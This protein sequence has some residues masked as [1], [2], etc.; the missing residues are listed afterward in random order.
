[1]KASGQ[2]DS[3]PLKGFFFGDNQSYPECH[4]STIIHLKNEDFTAS[5]IGGTKEKN[6]DAG[7]WMPKRK[8]G[9]WCK[10]LVLAYNPTTRDR[11]STGKLA[12]AISFDNGKPSP[13][14][15]NPEDGKLDEEF[16]YPS[17]INFND[18]IALTYTFH[19]KKIAYWMATKDRMVK[20]VQPM[21]PTRAKPKC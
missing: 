1:M 4:T 14:K 2:L 5:W 15:I 17:I 13:K 18:T 19:R 7:I 10:M 9:A 12:P 21:D 16:S 8:P 11:G 3:H 6:D 20:K